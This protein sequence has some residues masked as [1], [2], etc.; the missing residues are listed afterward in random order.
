MTRPGTST[1]NCPCCGRTFNTRVLYSTNNL[2]GTTTEFRPVAAGEQPTRY[3]VH[4][5]PD[6]GYSG[7]EADFGKSVPAH[8]TSLVAE[9]ITPLIR[10]QKPSAAQ[11][12][13]FAAW[14]AERWNE[15][16]RRV[17][18]CYLQAAWIQDASRSEPSAGERSATD[19]R[20]L[21]L[22]WYIKA[23][24]RELPLPDE[25]LTLVY[26]IG[27]LH[28]R[29]GDPTTA[30]LWFN[31]TITAADGNPNLAQLASLAR[32]QRDAPEEF[33]PRTSRQWP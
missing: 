6:C 1:L 17:G 31:R 32:Q 3:R 7:S 27:E 21:A 2:G 30:E 20:R 19:Y 14:I 13:E 4:S 26:L 24:D 15:V 16:P 12:F 8:V 25:S 11:R 23:V 9:R 22:N 10:E 18:D 5:C 28:R 29:T 33:I